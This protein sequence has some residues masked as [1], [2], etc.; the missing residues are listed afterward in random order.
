VIATV[1]NLTL[2]LNLLTTVREELAGARQVSTANVSLR[3][4][5]ATVGALRVLGACPDVRRSRLSVLVYFCKSGEKTFNAIPEMK[6]LP[7]T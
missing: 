6:L 1:K 5:N 7:S 2:R 3:S 4:W